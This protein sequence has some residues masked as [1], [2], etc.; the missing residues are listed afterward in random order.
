MH[1]WIFPFDVH[2]QAP[3][4]KIRKVTHCTVQEEIKKRENEEEEEEEEEEERRKDANKKKEG[5]LRK[6]ESGL[7]GVNK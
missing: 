1:H 3:T 5:K 6:K 2:S 4:R 7:K